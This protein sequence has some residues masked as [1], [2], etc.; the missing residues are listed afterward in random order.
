MTTLTNWLTVLL[1]V[2][3]ASVTIL[4][5]VLAYLTQTRWMKIFSESQGIPATIME[6]K[7]VQREV[8]Q[9]QPKP[10]KKL[11]SIPVPGGQLFKAK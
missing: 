1:A 6:S 7:P 9:P 10:R 2:S 11:F 3:L 4:V 5:T 8:V